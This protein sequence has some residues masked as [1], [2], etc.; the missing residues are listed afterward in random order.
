LNVELRDGDSSWNQRH[1]KGHFAGPKVPFGALIDF[2]PNTTK[3]K[4]QTRSKWNPKAVPGVFMGYFLQPGHVWKG[5]Y[6]AAALED[7]SDLDLRAD[8]KGVDAKLP[9]HRVRE[10]IVDARAGR[11]YKFPLK[12]EYDRRNRTLEGLGGDAAG[13]PAGDPLAP[14]CC[15]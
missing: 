12:A 13:A 9:I 11:G 7:C 5:E 6:L 10:L 14:P 15:P 3:R 8:A 1:G 2:I 4:W